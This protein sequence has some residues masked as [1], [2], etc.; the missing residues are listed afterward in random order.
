M[1]PWTSPLDPQGP[2]NSYTLSRTERAGRTVAASL[3]MHGWGWA[4]PPRASFLISHCSWAYAISQFIGL[5]VRIHSWKHVY[6]LDAMVIVTSFPCLLSLE[7]L[8]MVVKVT[9]I[10]PVEFNKACV[11]SLALHPLCPDLSPWGHHT[12]GPDLL[13]GILQMCPLFSAYHHCC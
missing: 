6:Y 8:S 11:V 5:I 7:R 3:A 2:Q 10:E 12:S 1:H 13:K 9:Y 4:V